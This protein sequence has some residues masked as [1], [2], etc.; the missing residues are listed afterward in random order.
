MEDIKKLRI[1][2][3]C[4]PTYGGSGVLATEL[5]IGL[6]EN[7][8]E[9]HFVSYR[10]PARLTSFTPRVFYHEINIFNYPLFEF[11]PY[12]S[13]L[14]SGLVDIVKCHKL[15]ILHV[16]YAIPHA[17]AA[18]LAKQ[19]LATEN[20]PI[21]V[22]T[23]LH[24]TDITLVGINNTFAPI[25][26]FS[27][28]AS[29]GITAVSESLKEDTIKNFQIQ[30]DI[31]VIYNF[32]NPNKFFPGEQ[33]E[34]KKQL[35]PNGEKIIV[36]AS[37]FRPVKKI[38]DILETFYLVHKKIPSKLLL[39]GDGPERQKAEAF[40]KAWNLS[41]DIIS[42]GKL[43]TLAPIFQV[44]DVFLLPSEHESFGLAA[45][46]AMACGVPVV[47]TNTG[48]LPELNIH[49]ETGF[50]CQVGDVKSMSEYIIQLCTDNSLWKQFSKQALEQASQFCLSGKIREYEQ[51][52]WK[53]L[54]Q[55][56]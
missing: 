51:Y 29:D 50:V 10:Q 52:Y 47:S 8:H 55:G 46:E 43:D 24:G 34:L 7:G 2:I 48:G 20:I 49:G 40:S 4:F 25:V 33:E 12:E 19:I 6:A 31:Q 15:D 26:R 56:N 35:A 9:V 32:Y 3:V 14:I 16:H 5:G 17:Y 36:H 41:E 18:Y 22:I 23:T 27:L 28:E 30:N 44:S 11:P 39:I 45:L 13:A 37:N 38:D 21:R 1:G 54:Q 53:V 42:F